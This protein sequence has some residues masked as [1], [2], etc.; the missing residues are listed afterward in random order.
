MSQNGGR[1]FEPGN[2]MGRGRPKGSR[3]KR[4]AEAQKI[5]DQYAAPLVK[6]CV[7]R[8]LDGDTRA[9]ALCLERILPPLREPGIQLRLPKL[10]EVKDVD[11]GVK[12]VLQGIGK[13]NITP[14]EGEKVASILQNYRET[15]EVQEMVQRI[16][17]LEKHAKEQE[18]RRRDERLSKKRSTA[19]T[20]PPGTPTS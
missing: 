2:T 19:P 15:I 10:D 13:G 14:V 11:L 7:A 1:P 18:S 4:S 9:L 5:L 6:R 17:A 8:A 3:N 12:R 16:E 20:T